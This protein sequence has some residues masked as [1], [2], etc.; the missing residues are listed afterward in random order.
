MTVK[1]RLQSHPRTHLSSTPPH[2]SLCRLLTSARCGCRTSTAVLHQELLPRPQHLYAV[3]ACAPSTSSCRKLCCVIRTLVI[4]TPRRVG[5]AARHMHA[6][7]WSLQRVTGSPSNQLYSKPI[8]VQT[9]CRV[10]QCI[11]CQEHSVD[12]AGCPPPPPSACV[13]L[14][15]PGNFQ[16]AFFVDESC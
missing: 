16:S 8:N 3:T 11:P 13:H 4:P 14:Y 6:E 2:H 9:M 15:P 5:C 12:V 7:A 10:D 1:A